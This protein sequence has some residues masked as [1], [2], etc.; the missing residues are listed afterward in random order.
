MTKVFPK[1]EVYSPTNQLRRCASS[2]PANIAE[3]CSVAK[4]IR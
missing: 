1:E 3:A 2:I 4:G